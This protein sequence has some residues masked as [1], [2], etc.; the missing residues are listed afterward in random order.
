MSVKNLIEFFETFS[1]VPVE[2]QHVLDHAVDSLGVQDTITIQPVDMDPEILLGILLR[3]IKHNNAYGEPIRCAIIVYNCNGRVSVAEQ[4]LACVKEIVHL[5]DVGSLKTNTREEII[6]LV[7]NLENFDIATP[8]PGDWQAV[9]DKLALYQALAVLVPHE[10]REDLMEPYHSG[11]IDDHWIAEK[12]SIPEKHVDL[13]MSKD[14][15]S[16]RQVLLDL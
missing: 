6:D 15:D 16:F 9:K 2:V 8:G 14:W 1:K 12:F 11:R 13:V 3:Y 4:R 7:D 5:F 10:I